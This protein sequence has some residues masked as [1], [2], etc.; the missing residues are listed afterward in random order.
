MA[1]ATLVDRK[2]ELGRQLLLSLDRRN[3]QVPAAFWFYVSEANDWRLIIAS[4]DVDSQGPRATY[5]K[6]QAAA[7]SDLLA[8]ELS[9]REISVV[10][11]KDPL[12]KLLGMAVST[13]HGISG[14][15]FT[16]NTINNTFIED[17]Y[18]YRLS[19]GPTEGHPRDRYKVR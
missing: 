7:D 10:S 18:I 1:S 15:R 6:I 16:Q 2:I 12:V 4:P 19:R 14:I 8:G 3:F 17:A 11:P 9:L 5:A 13:G